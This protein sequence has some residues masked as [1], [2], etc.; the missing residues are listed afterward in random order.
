MEKFDVSVGKFTLESLTTGMYSDARI[1]YREY[2]QNSVDS[3]E[4]AVEL[5]IIKQDEMRINIVADSINNHIFIEDN[6]TGVE[7]ENAVSV[8]LNIGDST[9]R[10]NNNRGF[11]GIGRLGGMSYCDKLVFSTSAKGEAT[12]TRISFDCMELRRL[13]LPG[14]EEHEDLV[15]LLKKITTIER[16]KEEEETHYFIVDLFGVD[17]T[18]GLLE[19]DKIRTYIE[20]VAPLPYK[21]SQFYWC[22]EIKKYLADRGYDIEEFPIY[23]G[24]N[25]ANKK[26]LYKLNRNR[27]KSNRSKR[28][29]DEIE[30]LELFEIIIDDELYAVGWYGNCN[31]LGTMSDLEMAGLR[32]RKGNILIGDRTTLNPIFDNQSRFNAWVQGELFVL[33]DDLIPNARRDDFEKNEAY[34]KLINKMIKDIGKPLI[35]KIRAA[36]VERNDAVGKTIRN[37]NIT[38]KDAQKELEEGYNSKIDKEAAIQTIDDIE[39]VLEGLPKNISDERKEIKRE[40]KNKADILKSQIED[41]SHYKMDE[42]GV[43]LDRKSKKILY[44]VSEVL[45]EKLSKEL[46]DLIIEGIKEKLRER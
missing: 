18:T 15:S 26:P 22:S 10:S 20:E 35:S 27:F 5:N 33:K 12:A 21:Q 16:V 43:S 6:G 34:N 39:K 11:R 37:I 3:L 13:M 40:L 17:E 2:I 45:S 7:S 41:S 14:M 19:G 46:A 1:V 8:L 29:S 31:W 23:F 24:T 9:K 28:E 32:I 30:S 36:S 44:I 38:L 42:L 4:N 25:I